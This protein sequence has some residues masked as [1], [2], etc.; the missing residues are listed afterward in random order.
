MIQDTLSISP[1]NMKSQKMAPL[2][3]SLLYRSILSQIN[4][5]QEDVQYAEEPSMLL[6]LRDGHN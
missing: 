3:R 2:N 5:R 4:E 6:K 1:P